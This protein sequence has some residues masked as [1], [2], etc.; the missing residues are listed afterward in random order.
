[1]LSGIVEE[2]AHGMRRL[3]DYDIEETCKNAKINTI[4]A[5]NV[6]ITVIPHRV[7][8]DSRL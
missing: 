3:P 2:Y 5:L 6:L 8:R 7:A 1:M 4:A